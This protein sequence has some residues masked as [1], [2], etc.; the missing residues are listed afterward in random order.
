MRENMNGILM[1]ISK[2][3]ERAIYCDRCHNEIRVEDV[4]EELSKKE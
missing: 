3:S 2:K 1:K 4:E